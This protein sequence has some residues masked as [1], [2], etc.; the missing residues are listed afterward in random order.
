MAVTHDSA[1][2]SDGET[3][4]VL[5]AL[6]RILR[7]ADLHSRDLVRRAGLTAPQLAVLQA[8]ADLGEVTTGRISQD[9]SL[10]QATVTVV[11]DRLVARGLV[12]RYRNPSD[13]RIVHSRLTV[14]G[15][16]A[17]AEAAPLLNER[18]T[19]AY[20]ALPE[21]ERDGVVRALGWAATALEAV[22]DDL[23]DGE[24]REAE[25]Q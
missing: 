16:A 19:R 18:L 21:D 7:A 13:R 12:E 24:D 2:R 15:L 25:G 9:V 3:R 6:R 5:A 4:V 8:I 10:S 20:A 1:K 17:L 22:A 23:P 11:L 14:P